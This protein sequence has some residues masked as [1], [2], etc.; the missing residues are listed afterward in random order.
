VKIGI[1]V[2]EQGESILVGIRGPG[3]PLPGF[4]EFPGGKC[5][6]DE[7]AADCAVR[8]CLEETGLVVCCETLLLETEFTYPHGT[9]HLAFFH[10]RLADEAGSPA[11]ANGFRWCPRAELGTL[12]F[13][14]G[15]RE[16]VRRLVA[17]PSST[18][19]PFPAAK[20]R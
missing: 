12:D 7:S 15:N 20:E 3:G 19:E 1:A 17:A 13:P 11:P 8:E 6:A 5:H 9:V 16:V 18:A 2:V 4:A 10:C 14:E